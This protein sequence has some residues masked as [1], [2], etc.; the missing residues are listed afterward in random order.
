M[1][2]TP[3]K[4]RQ[5]LAKMVR[6]DCGRTLANIKR[7]CMSCTADGYRDRQRLYGQQ[8]ANR[9]HVREHRWVMQ[10]HIGRPLLESPNTVHHKNGIRDDN[11][12][13]NLEL[14]AQLARGRHR[15]AGH[16]VMPTSWR[17]VP[18]I[19]RTV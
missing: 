18:R 14:M 2:G 6:S 5:H 4:A 1:C 16:R 8:N 15:C 3:T 11:R 7:S 10:Q 17:V 9:Q 12:I 13:E 19:H